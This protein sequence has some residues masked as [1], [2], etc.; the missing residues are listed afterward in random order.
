[1]C[2]RHL[3]KPVYMVLSPERYC[4]KDSDLLNINHFEYN[5]KGV[6]QPKMKLLS[7]FTQL[8][9]ISDLCD[10]LQMF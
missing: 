6:I 2:G 5:I 8:H 3:M 10:V 7:S 1:M 9:V 4:L